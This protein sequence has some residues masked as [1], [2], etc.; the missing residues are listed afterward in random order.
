[1]GRIDV[2]SIH[3]IG[4]H[5]WI[6]IS[7]GGVWRVKDKS[8]MKWL[9]ADLNYRIFTVDG[10]SMLRKSWI[11]MNERI[12]GEIGK[13]IWRLE[14]DSVKRFP[15]IPDRFKK[16]INGHMVVGGSGGAWCIRGDSAWQ[17]TDVKVERVDIVGD[18][19]WVVSSKGAWRVEGDRAVRIPDQEINVK[20]V[21]KIAGHIWISGPE[22]AWR[23]EGDRAVRIPDQEIDVKIVEKVAGHIWI[24]GPE[25][26]W[27]VE[28]DRA[29][30]IP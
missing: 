10:K 25:G 18:H 8:L 14:E 9:D 11:K 23:V 5:V 4:D 20:K 12:D 21:E 7:S 3:K 29:V 17:I 27:R 6:F 22:G 1:M 19:I 24:S 26:A 15:G 28:G 30:R 13:R 16:R 2:E